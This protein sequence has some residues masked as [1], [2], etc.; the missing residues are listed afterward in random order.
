MKLQF[1]NRDKVQRLHGQP[2]PDS[3]CLI[4]V[5]QSAWRQE[6]CPYC[7]GTGI[8]IQ[9]WPWDTIIHM[10]TTTGKDTIPGTDI[11]VIYDREDKVYRRK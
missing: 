11:E 6:L 8:E 4:C 5:G 1:T 9:T 3:K 7:R 10:S 2:K